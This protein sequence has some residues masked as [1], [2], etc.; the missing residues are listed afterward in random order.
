MAGKI[1]NQLRCALLHLGSLI[2][3]DFKRLHAVDI[4]EIE[5]LHDLSRGISAA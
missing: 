4:A 5:E 2:A 1:T 3:R